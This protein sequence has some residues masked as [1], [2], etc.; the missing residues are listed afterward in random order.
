VQGAFLVLNDGN[1]LHFV[2]GGRRV[3]PDDTLSRV[4]FESKDGAWLHF[5]EPDR[6]TWLSLFQE[7]NAIDTT[8][9][10]PASERALSISALQHDPRT[11]RLS[12]VSN[13][14]RPCFFAGVPL[15]S[16]NGHNIGA[17]CVVNGTERPPL[18]VSEAEILADTAQ[19]C[20]NLLELARERSIYS[21]WTSV[22]EEVDTFLNS[23]SLHA[24]LLEE[25]QTPA[26]RKSTP[27]KIEADKRDGHGGE[28]VDPDTLAEDSLSGLGDPPVE[29]KESERLVDAEAE[30]DRRI[31]EKDNAQNARSL[32]AKRGKDD[33]R[34][35]PKGETTYRKVF[36]RAA[37]CLRTALQADGVLFV[38]GLIGFHGDAQPAAEP[39]QELERE[40]A[41][42]TGSEGTPAQEN[43]VSTTDQ[44]GVEE[45][46]FD[47][48]GPD[49]PGTHS[50][51]YTSAEFLRG[52]YGSRPSEILGLSGS[53]HVLKRSRI[54]ESTIGLSEID[55]GFLQRLMD[56]HPKGVVWYRSQSR[57]MEVQDGTL[58]EIDLAE[59]AQRLMTTFEQ[60]SQLMF[61]PLTDPSSLKRL[62]GCFAWR[63]ASLPLFT[64]AVDLGSLKAF[65]H[66]VESEFARFDAAS[67]AKQKETFVSSV[68][69]ELSLSLHV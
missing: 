68:S 1:R 39:E 36:R 54:S 45:D 51:V 67:A 3:D 27:Q 18:S 69:H 30:R 33:E 61:K 19:R 59:E 46:Q 20:T 64:D 2:A 35:L 56:R 17:I 31:A 28:R 41:R 34:G 15:T 14:P 7:I 24:Q 53:D 55:E 26:G 4:E 23:R 63:T 37:Q 42:P 5:K 11:S 8:K 48:H 38:D 52:V 6:S 10:G 21:R 43:A 40:I 60:V 44:N 66:I 9:S 62:G 47:P 29:G 50:R 65:L 16:K 32:T 58:V 12:L 13:P 49:P 22:Q 57:L 25:P